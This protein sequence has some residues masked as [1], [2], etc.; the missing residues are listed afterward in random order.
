MVNVD[1]DIPVMD[2]D[3]GAAVC[4]IWSSTFLTVSCQKTVC[5]Q[6]TVKDT[7]Q[8]MS[9][10]TSEQ[11]IIILR[12]WYRGLKNIQSLVLLGVGL[13]H[14]K[15][16]S[17]NK[18]SQNIFQWLA[19]CRGHAYPLFRFFSSQWLIQNLGGEFLLSAYA[20]GNNF[21]RVCMSVCP[22]HSI[23]TT[24]ARNFIFQY[25]DARSLGQSCKQKNH[26]LPNFTSTCIK[27]CSNYWGHL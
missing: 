9:F 20:V 27:Y 23:W 8:S 17:Q 1:F 15:R 6:A 7:C 12:F 2:H 3:M 25:A 18:T 11:H 26:I 24:G 22:G 13:S 16:T 19:Q 10:S 21:S 5:A 4:S 14:G